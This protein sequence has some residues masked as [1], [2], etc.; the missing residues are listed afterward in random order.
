MVMEAHDS[1]EY[2]AVLNSADLVVPDG[3]PLIWLLRRLGV[4]AQE[5][6]AG[7]DLTPR[8]CA[9]AARAGISVGVFGGRT[10]VL[11]AAVGTLKGLAPQLNVAFTESP[12][13]RPLDPLEDSELVERINASGVSILFVALGCPK[14][15]RWMHE[16]RG[17]VNTVMIGIGA[18]LD[19]LGG[20][21][22][23]AP[24]WMQRWGLEWLFRLATEPKRLWRRYLNH[25]FRFLW[26]TRTEL[27]RTAR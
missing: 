23:R 3:M 5:R 25:N 14:Q 20:A 27:T 7:P 2:K 1:P 12:P 6:V 18:A 26:L 17:R 8:L 21:V 9:A 13:F 16:H 10:D 19:F 15:E 11:R 4:G 22:P 24:L